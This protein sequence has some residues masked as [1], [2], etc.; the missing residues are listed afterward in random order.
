MC[1]QSTMFSVTD[2][3]SRFTRT[4][5]IH[6]YSQ[7]IHGAQYALQRYHFTKAECFFFS[8]SLSPCLSC[9]VYFVCIFGGTKNK[10]FHMWVSRQPQR[11]HERCEWDGCSSVI[12]KILETRRRH[13]G[14]GRSMQGQ[15]Y[16][17]IWPYILPQRL[18][19]NVHLIVQ[20]RKSSIWFQRRHGKDQS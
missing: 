1:E 2:L 20:P 13:A 15:K 9:A 17:I 6:W 4:H 16:P 3:H 18:N 19:R 14:F 10:G 5:R 7:G 12:C 8:I 11:T